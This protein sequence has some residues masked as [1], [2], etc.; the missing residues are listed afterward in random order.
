VKDVLQGEAPGF[1]DTGIGNRSIGEKSEERRG[2]EEETGLSKNSPAQDKELRKEYGEIIDE[3]K[4]TKKRE[5]K[6]R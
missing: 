6:R 1:F 4:K 2:N 5:R 3:K